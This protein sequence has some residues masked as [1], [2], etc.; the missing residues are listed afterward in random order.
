MHWLPPI[1]VPKVVVAR[2]DED[3]LVFAP[4]SCILHET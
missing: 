3:V 2:D 4:G 1:G